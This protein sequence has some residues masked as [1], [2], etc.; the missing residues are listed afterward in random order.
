MGTILR[1]SCHTEK[2]GA[3][4]ESNQKWSNKRKARGEAAILCAWRQPENDGSLV[5]GNNGNELRFAGCR[6]CRTTE[7]GWG[8]KGMVLVCVAAEHTSPDV[9]WDE[10]GM[11]VV[12]MDMSTDFQIVIIN[13][14]GQPIYLQWRKTKVWGSALGAGI[15]RY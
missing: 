1:V 5:S 8:T 2:F 15:W 6:G 12:Q 11:C 13:G 4:T 14:G 9:G 7:L 10:G 3:V